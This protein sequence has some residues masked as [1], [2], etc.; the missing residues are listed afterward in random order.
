MFNQKETV[1]YKGKLCEVVGIEE[2]IKWGQCYHLKTIYEKSPWTIQVPYENAFQNIRKLP[3]KDEVNRALVEAMYVDSMV[4][5]RNSVDRI[6]KPLLDSHVVRDWLILLRELL[7]HQ[8]VVEATGKKFLLKE[9][10]YLNR[11]SEQLI[12][13]YSYVLDM[14]EEDTRILLFETFMDACI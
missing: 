9:Q 13:L 3:T 2:S 4:I 6:C 11:V 8:A 1:L 5:E 12:P 7:N 14:N 10:D